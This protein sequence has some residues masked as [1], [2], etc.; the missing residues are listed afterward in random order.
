MTSDEPNP[1][2]ESQGELDAWKQRVRATL[3]KLREYP[4]QAPLVDS[5]DTKKETEEKS[6]ATKS[7]LQKAQDAHYG[8]MKWAARLRVSTGILLIL[9]LCL[10]IVAVN[11]IICEIGRAAEWK[12]DPAAALAALGGLVA[13]VVTL[14][15]VVVKWIYSPPIDLA[16]KEGHDATSRK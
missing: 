9:L 14:A 16:R 11:W 2:P 13:Q 3:S 8:S 1:S 15:H 4:R 10:Q 12:L 7:E 5:T 6:K